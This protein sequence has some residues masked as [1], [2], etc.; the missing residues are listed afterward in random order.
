MV[1]VSNACLRSNNMNLKNCT[2]T[3][4]PIP[5]EN[6]AGRVWE[7]GSLGSSVAVVLCYRLDD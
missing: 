6:T 7:T 4:A 3:L 5:G 2:G 1:K